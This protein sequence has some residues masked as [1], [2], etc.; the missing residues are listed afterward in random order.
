MVIR[1]GLVCIL[2]RKIKVRRRQAVGEPQSTGLLHLMVRV[3]AEIES[4]KNAPA[5]AGAFFVV[6]RLGLEPRT[7]ALK[8]RC[9]TD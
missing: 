2:L 9:S 6:T 8:G 4:T 3:P 1:L 5:E 7:P